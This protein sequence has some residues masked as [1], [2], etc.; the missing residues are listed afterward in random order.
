MKQYLVAGMVNVESTVKVDG[1]PLEYMPITYSDFDIVAGVSGGAYNVGKALTV[2]GD[3]VELVSMIGN[4]LPGK[5]VREQLKEDGIPDSN[6]MTILKET[7]QSV[8]LYDKG[9]KRQIFCDLK[10]MQ[11]VDFDEKKF[12]SVVKNADMVV[13]QNSNFCRPFLKEVKESGK[14]IA[15]SVHALEE[16]RDKY[17][18][19]FMECA[20]ILFISDNNLEEDPYDFIT[21]IEKKYKNKII[22]LGCGEKG[23]L[24]YVK[25][26]K[27]IGSFPSVKTREVVNVL[28]AGDALFSAFLH[29]YGK[30]ENPYTSLKKAILFSS[31]KIGAAGSAYGFIT[32]DQIDQYYPI[33]WK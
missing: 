21:K 2:L 26:D 7:P 31:Y 14:T 22:I 16:V 13:F 32:E 30:T 29:F 19:D 5:M 1:F 28:G 24:L 3:K 33:I 4:D 12:M 6:V 8:I 15:A 10:E 20:D 27:F 23:A 17:N 18:S 25:K 11:K 9:R